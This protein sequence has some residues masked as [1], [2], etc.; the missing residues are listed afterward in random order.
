MAGQCLSAYLAV[1][2][3]DSWLR[4]P[5][6]YMWAVSLDYKESSHDPGTCACVIVHIN[7]NLCPDNCA[8]SKMTSK[9]S[10][11]CNARYNRLVPL[12][13][14]ERGAYLRV[15][16]HGGVLPELQAKDVDRHRAIGVDATDFAKV[17]KRPSAMNG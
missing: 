13:Y 4:P 11:Q 3:S 2:H 1:S 14:T 6:Q 12:L 9:H 7:G 10:P 15:V 8:C 16:T 17:T 5:V